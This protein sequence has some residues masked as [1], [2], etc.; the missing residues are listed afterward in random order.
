MVL[1][2]RFLKFHLRRMTSSTLKK[3][4][5]P[6]A[7]S[8]K[9]SLPKSHLKSSKLMQKK[10]K[11]SSQSSSLHFTKSLCRS[12][13]QRR[14]PQR[15]SSAQSTQTQNQKISSQDFLRNKNSRICMVREFYLSAV[16]QNTTS[17]ASG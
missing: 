10:A 12:R 4:G 15:Q 6:S 8:M 9:K 3:Y 2:Q 1:H 14:K 7:C 5:I 16:L 17:S 13:R 11:Q